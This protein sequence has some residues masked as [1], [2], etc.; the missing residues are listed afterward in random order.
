MIM[1][2]RKKKTPLQD[3]W[4]TI[5]VDIVEGPPPDPNRPR[6]EFIRKKI[7][8]GREAIKLP[9]LPERFYRKMEG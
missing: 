2:K 6:P 3:F 4:A 5:E 1:K 9:G 7:E 8:Q